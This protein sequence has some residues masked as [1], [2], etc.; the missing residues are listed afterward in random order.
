MM[1][2]KTD[3]RTLHIKTSLKTSLKFTVGG[4]KTKTALLARLSTSFT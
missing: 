3:P 4:K 1:K 2:C